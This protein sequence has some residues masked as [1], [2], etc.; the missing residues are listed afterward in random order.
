MDLPSPDCP[1]VQARLEL[2][3]SLPPKYWFYRHAP[4]LHSLYS[5]F[6]EDISLLEITN[7][8]PYIHLLWEPLS[9][10]RFL[11]LPSNP[12]TQVWPLCRICLCD[13]GVAAVHDLSLRAFCFGLVFMYVYMFMFTCVLACVWGYACHEWTSGV[14]V[15]Q[16]HFTF[17]EAWSLAESG[18]WWFLY[19]F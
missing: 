6:E 9:L 1:E 19:G 10:I 16:S 15:F 2:Y 5:Y 3:L 8:F 18:A 7:K 4:P 17:L 12:V 13:T 14:S 11:L